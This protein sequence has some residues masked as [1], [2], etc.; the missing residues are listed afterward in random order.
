MQTQEP[1]HETTGRGEESRTADTVRLAK[2]KVPGAVT[3]CNHVDKKGAPCPRWGLYNDGTRCACHTTERFDRAPKAADC[4]HI[5]KKGNPCT[6]PANHCDG[7]RCSC[8]ASKRLE[9]VTTCENEGCDKQ[10]RSVFGRCREH[11]SGV[12]TRVSRI[13]AKEERERERLEQA[14]A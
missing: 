8:H 2:R 6:R 12:R 9:P 5:D 10:T 7:T 11:C 13:R 4:Q 14:E 1:T 3:H